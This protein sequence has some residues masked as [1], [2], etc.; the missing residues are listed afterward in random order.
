[1][2][3]SLSSPPKNETLP[4]KSE[5]L[6]YDSMVVNNYP[7]ERGEYYNVINKDGEHIP[8]ATAIS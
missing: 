6:G 4:E 1:M 8:K 5:R 7:S 2:G 3:F